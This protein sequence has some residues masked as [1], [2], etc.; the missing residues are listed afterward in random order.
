MEIL[1]IIAIF[2]ALFGL[3]TFWHFPAD[4]L[5]QNHMEAIKKSKDRKVRAWHCLKYALAFVPLLLLMRTRMNY[6]GP[7]LLADANFYGALVI[8]F[9]SHYIID[10]YIPVMLWA[11]YIRKDPVFAQVRPMVK[12]SEK[13]EPRKGWEDKVVDQ[14]TQQWLYEDD[15]KALEAMF[16]RPVGA[17][18]CITM[19]QLFHIICLLPIPILMMR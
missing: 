5:F 16:T 12:K 1:I 17:I 6:D 8:L 18:L 7:T 2:A 13:K 10:S 15:G 19:D 3:L 4:W 11:K 9:V 14:P